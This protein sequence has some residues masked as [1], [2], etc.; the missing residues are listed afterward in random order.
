MIS[1]KTLINQLVDTSELT[2]IQPWLRRMLKQAADVLEHKCAPVKYFES[3]ITIEPIF[4]EAA[5][6]QATAIAKKYGF[7][8]AELLMQRARAGTPVRSNKDSFMTARD[9]D[10]SALMERMVE[11]AEDFKRHN[12]DVY[13]MKIEAV[14]FDERTPKGEM[15]E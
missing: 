14:V 3:H 11:C 13:R 2:V 12:Y 10:E 5:L 9:T 1:D 7:R 8:M 6:K 15:F 4:D